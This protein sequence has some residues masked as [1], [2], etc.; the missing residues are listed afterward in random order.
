MCHPA[1]PTPRLSKRVQ[2]APDGL[3]A[4]FTH[5]LDS[6]MI[7]G[8]LNMQCSQWLNCGRCPSQ[9][10]R[11]NRKALGAASRDTRDR[12]ITTS[13]RRRR[14]GEYR[15][16][17][18]GIVLM[19][20]AASTN[21]RGCEQREMTKYK[22]EG[23]SPDCRKGVVAEDSDGQEGRSE[24]GGRTRRVSFVV[25]GLMWEWVGGLER[26]RRWC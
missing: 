5:R 3:A 6:S 24:D 18:A 19:A 14:D 17:I 12:P 10:L 7:R 15:E 1:L 9:E 8:A 25:E 23:I 13:T 21:S 16:T 11:G 2:D 4:R 26:E 20:A 22:R